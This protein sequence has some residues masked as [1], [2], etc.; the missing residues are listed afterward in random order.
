MVGREFAEIH[1]EQFDPRSQSVAVEIVCCI[2]T[3]LDQPSGSLE[4]LGNLVNTDALDEIIRD[5]STNT[6]PPVLVSF[7]YVG[8]KIIVSSRGWYSVMNTPGSFT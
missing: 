5:R 1:H 8:F 6:G 7:D 3:L 2:S 4:P